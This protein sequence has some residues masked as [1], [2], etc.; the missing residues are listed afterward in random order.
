MANADLQS[1]IDRM[2]SLYR[3]KKQ[4]DEMLADLK[5]EIDSS[6]FDKSAVDDVVKRMMMDEAKLEKLKSREE[7]RRLYADTIGQSD[8]FGAN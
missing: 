7:Q 5:K 2:A 1:F 3:E 4:C 8:L 6:G